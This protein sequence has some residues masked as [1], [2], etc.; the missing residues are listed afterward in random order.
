[1]SHISRHIISMFKVLTVVV[2]LFVATP[3]SSYGAR[4]NDKLLN[5]PYA[6][7]RAWHLGFGFG[8]HA[9]SL[10]FTHNGFVTEGG[11]T[12]FMEQPAYSPGFCVNGLI[13]FRLS[14]Y[15]N[16]RISPGMYFGNRDI[17]MIDTTFGNEERQNIKS[18][19]VVLPV[20]L[21]CSSLRYR[22]VRPYA[23]VGVLPAFDVSKR[24]ADFFQL[25]TADLYLTFGFGCDFYL[26]FFKFIPEL[27]F[28]LGL[29]DV[30]RHD[31]P[32]LADNPEALKFTQSLS[33]AKSSMVV[34]T[35]YFE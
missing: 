1:M 30:L 2:C 12:W 23:T 11:E 20:D 32:D 4:L 6:D 14:T 33:K 24:R 16:V 34:L 17:R 3:L 18:T 9:Q 5:R 26:P 35:F 25:N 22:N 19:F 31:R 7:N 29:T 28:C 21:K 27:K 13:D 10:G 15:F 8:V